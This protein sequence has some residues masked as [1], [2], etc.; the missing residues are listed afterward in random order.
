[1]KK[2]IEFSNFGFSTILLCF[3][4]ICV[5]TFSALS[6]VS[7]YSD[8]KLSKKVADKNADYYKAQERAYETVA[9]IDTL[10]METYLATASSSDYY[11]AM[12]EKAAAYGSVTK[13]TDSLILSFTES[14][15][16]DHTL[17]ISLKICYPSESN[18]SF[19]RIVEWK[20]HY[21]KAAPED[22][23]LD[24]IK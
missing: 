20:S 8:Y 2:K 3:V 7:A 4:M 6:L 13:D 1:M 14:I 9:L 19:V 15:T 11:A 24:L 10:A 17:C 21:D 22:D 23:Y 5:V 16:T 12:Q 18:E